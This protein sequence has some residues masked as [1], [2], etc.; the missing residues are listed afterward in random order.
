MSWEKLKELPNG[1]VSNPRYPHLGAAP[2]HGSYS[3]AE[4]GGKPTRERD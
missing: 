3:Q 1:R 2:Y 4:G